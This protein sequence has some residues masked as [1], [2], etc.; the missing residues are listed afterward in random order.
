MHKLYIWESELLRDYTKGQI[1]VCAMNV[2]DARNT[3]RD[4]FKVWLKERGSDDYSQKLMTEFERDIASMPTTSMVH[5]V[6]G[7]C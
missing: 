2:S 7:D 4:H 1:I 3:A 6:N 5:F